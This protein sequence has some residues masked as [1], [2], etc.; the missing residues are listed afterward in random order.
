MNKYE[1]AA[2]IIL[3]HLGGRRFVMMTGAKQLLG[4]ATSLTFSLPRTPHYVKQGINKVRI[5]LTQM[6][7]YTMEC[8][9]LTKKGCERITYSEDLFAEDLQPYF[10]RATGLETHL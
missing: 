2:Q 4:D 9:K 10:T 6:D 3:T 8:F 1:L 7:T 5:T